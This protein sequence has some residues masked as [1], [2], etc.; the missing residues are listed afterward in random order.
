V[1]VDAT[2]AISVQAGQIVPAT[3]RTKVS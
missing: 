1:V 3:T 2:G